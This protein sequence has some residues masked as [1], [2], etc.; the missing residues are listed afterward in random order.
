M[1]TFFADSSRKPW[2]SR[3]QRRQK[4]TVPFQCALSTKAGC[5]CVAHVD[6][7]FGPRTHRHFDRR[8]WGAPPFVRCFC[9]TPSPRDGSHR[10]PPHADVIRTGAP[11]S[12]CSTERLRG[13]ELL[14]AWMTSM[15]CADPTVLGN[16][17]DFG[18]GVANRMQKSGCIWVKPRCGTVVVCHQMGLMSCE[19]G[20]DC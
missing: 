10:D 11:S 2:P 9:G 17:R 4:Q 16:L 3:C 1:E 19:E 6:H 8:D 13:N 15:L 14:F 7:G 18:T 12:G 20:P 5:E